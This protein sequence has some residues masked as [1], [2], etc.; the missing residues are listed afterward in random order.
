MS[1]RPTGAYRAT[2][3]G[4]ASLST[5]SKRLLA[6]GAVTLVLAG[7]L[8]PG[9]GAVAALEVDLLV[10]A[11]ILTIS[12]GL[13]EFGHL[14]MAR[15]LHLRVRSYG[16]FMGPRV[17]SRRWSGIEWRLNL[18]PIGGYVS[19]QGED[20]DEGPG[21]FRTA[22]AWKKVLV[23]VV[24]SLVNLVLAYLALIAIAAPVYWSMF[25]GNLAKTVQ[26]SWMFANV[27]VGTIASSTSAAFAGFAPHAA[28]NPLDSPFVG[29]PGMVRASG[30]FAAQGVDGLLLFFAAI[31]LSLFLVNLMPIPPLDGGQTVLA[32]LRRFLGRLVTERV[33]RGMATVGL[34]A[35]I[36]FVVFVNLVDV[37]RMVSGIPFQK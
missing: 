20:R 35:L 14:L 23:Y 29:L 24:G 8:A 22:P 27:M 5:R 21:S 30:L 1:S 19:L 2:S 13:H 6:L 33:A 4:L 37:V 32:I 9:L 16:L 15:L 18:L 11:V 10:L 28:T 34:G 12:V 31:N 7:A 3:A 17:A 26:G 25:S 36:T